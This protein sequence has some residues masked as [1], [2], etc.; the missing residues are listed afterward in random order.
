M[1][2]TA[3]LKSPRHAVVLAAGKSTRFRSEL[4]KVLHPLCG[5]PLLEHV[6]G[7]L[8]GLADGRLIVVVGENAAGVRETA[9]AYGAECVLQEPQQGTGHAVMSALPVLEEQDGAVLVLYGDTPLIRVETL[10]RLFRAVEE[11]GA[12]E[13]IL[14]VETDFPEGYGRIVRDA[15]GEPA[16]IV[17]EKDA[18]PSEK[19]IREINAGFA[20]FRLSSL[21][22]GLPLL[23]NRNQAGEY[24]LTDLVQILRAAG[25]RIV[26][27]SSELV[28]ETLGVN[29]RE[30]LAQV[31]TFMRAEINRRWMRHG[32]TILNPATVAIDVE[33]D[34]QPDTTVYPGVIIEGKSVVGRGCTL[35][36]YSHL[37]NAVLEENVLVDHCSV[38]RNSTVGRNSQIGPFAHIRENTSIGAQ[39]RIGNFVEVKKCQ[40]GDESKAAH[41]AYLGDAQIGRDVNIGAGTITCNYDGINKNQ[42]VIEDN[43]FVGSDSQ[44]IAPVTIHR[45]AYVAA[46]S[47]IT[48][49][50]PEYALGIARGRQINKAGW[51]A[52]RARQRAEKSRLKKQKV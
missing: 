15:E 28:R 47:S 16:R 34:L 44:L 42:T 43:V 5:K 48:E 46:G 21:R 33:V 39:A 23:Q 50:V 45:G 6:L 35:M 10:E 36:S 19:A 4:P 25:G 11:D 1:I 26:T 9:A 40:V 7:K 29:S 30:E 3:N 51:A 18:S 41:L 27:V 52:E 13:A 49:D 14:T 32:V 17:E 8:P 38:I 12:H 37:R 31:E 24:Y 20:C 22:S 2:K